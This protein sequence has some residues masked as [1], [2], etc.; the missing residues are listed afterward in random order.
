MPRFHVVL[1]L[2]E[3]R[4]IQ[5]LSVMSEESN[6]PYGAAPS[7]QDPFAAA[8]ASAIKA[9]EELRAAAAAKAQE[10][11]SA[12]EVRAQHLRETA[13]EKVN[14]FRGYADKTWTDARS[15]AKNYASDAEAFAKEKPLHA[16]LTA[17]GIGLIAGI[18]LKK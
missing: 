14:E 13:G 18:L 9:A 10:I 8:K 1:V 17:F 11:R 3:K 2:I 15:Q 4:N 12:A 16:L 7:A 6:N 5:P